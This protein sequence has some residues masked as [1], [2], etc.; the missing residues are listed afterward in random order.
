MPIQNTE[1]RGRLNTQRR[2]RTVEYT[3]KGTVECSVP[4]Y[5][6]KGTVEYTEKG[7]V[8]CSVPEPTQR[9]ERLNAQKRVRFKARFLNTERR[10]R[11]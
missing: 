5:R 2:G 9:R 8:Q 4:E 7:E 1:R 3:E 6:E 10:G 11:F